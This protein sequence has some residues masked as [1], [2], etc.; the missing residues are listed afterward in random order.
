M[1]V[2]ADKNRLV[3]PTF[4]LHGDEQYDKPFSYSNYCNLTSCTE[5]TST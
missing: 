2:N 3:E 5:L 4:V 1:S